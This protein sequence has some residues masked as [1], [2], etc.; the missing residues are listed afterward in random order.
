MPTAMK[1]TKTSFLTATTADVN[2]VWN[3][4]TAAQS[5]QH[6]PLMSLPA[7]VNAPKIVMIVLWP[8]RTLTRTSA[9]ANAIS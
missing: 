9:D 6:L 1:R 3:K 2:A 7:N 4:P 8:S 5:Q